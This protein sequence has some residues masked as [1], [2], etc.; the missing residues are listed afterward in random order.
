MIKSI[1]S[2]FEDIIALLPV[3]KISSEFQWNILRNAIKGLTERVLFTWRVHE[4][5]GNTDL[6]N[7]STK[8]HH[9]WK[10]ISLIN[11]NSYRRETLDIN[12]MNVL[13]RFQESLRKVRN[14]NQYFCL[15]DDMSPKDLMYAE[16]GFNMD[17]NRYIDIIPL[18]HSKIT[19]TKG[20]TK[21]INANTL[22]PFPY[23][24]SQGP[25]LCT[26]QDH[27]QMIAQEKIS[28]I[29]MLCSSRE[30]S[31][32]WPSTVGNVLVCP[33]YD[34]EV[35]YQSEEDHGYFIIRTFLLKDFSG[36]LARIIKHFNYQS[37]P[38]FGVPQT[39]EPFLNFVN[40]IQNYENQSGVFPDSQNDLIKLVHC[41]AGIE[42]Q[43]V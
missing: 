18:E 31:Q 23:I 37:W 30:C 17:L 6:I 21:Y 41:L 33:K 22:Y 32:Y 16:D 27:W 40:A 9:I 20:Q 5:S 19:L 28:I 14:W 38:D 1:S 29:V 11:T 34:L 3:N 8:R 35:L 7:Y 25:L 2:P 15:L 26:V 42:Q 10:S 43:E 39:I 4:F 24:L 13:R 12:I 36:K